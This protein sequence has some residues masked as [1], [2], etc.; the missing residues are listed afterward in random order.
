MDIIAV[1]RSEKTMAIRAFISTSIHEKRI[2]F[3]KICDWSQWMYFQLFFAETL[4]LNTT[5]DLH[6]IR[7]KCVRDGGAKVTLVDEWTIQK[8]SQWKDSHMLI[9]EPASTKEEGK[10]EGGGIVHGLLGMQ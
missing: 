9:D 8:I 1:N 7:E 10:V 2:G 4:L 3:R 5:K 6:E